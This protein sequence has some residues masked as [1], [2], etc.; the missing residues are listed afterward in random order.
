MTMHLKLSISFL[1]CGENYGKSIFFCLYIFLQLR[2]PAAKTTIVI[3]VREEN[4]DLKMFSR[5]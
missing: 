4:C 2:L 3:E 1:C 5:K